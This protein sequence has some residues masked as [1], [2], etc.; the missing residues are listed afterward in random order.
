VAKGDP[1]NQLI[2]SNQNLA[3]LPETLVEEIDKEKPLEE[4]SNGSDA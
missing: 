2:L 3:E 4:Q 1:N